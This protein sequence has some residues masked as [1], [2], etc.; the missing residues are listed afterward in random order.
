MSVKHALL[1][2]LYR[3]AMHGYELGKQLPQALRGEWDVKPGQ[4]AST[5]SRLERDGL[6]EHH[7]ESG[8]N[9]PDRKVYRLTEQGL[10][11]L[12]TWF[13]TPEVE[14]YRVRNAF[15]I[16]LV[17]SLIQAP[18]PPETVILHQRRRLFQELHA[19]TA[20]RE[21][22]DPQCDLPFLLLLETAIIHLDADIRW[23]EMCE[24][25]LSELKRY[26]PSD[27]PPPPRGRPPTE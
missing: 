3:E 17:F 19:I 14:D 23:L 26:R 15:Y 24:A 1:A 13:V 18:V 7:V 5:L 22:L 2:L 27:L 11:E 8:D 6:I 20:L 10:A 12:T 4:I 9:A 21:T 25:R 16:K